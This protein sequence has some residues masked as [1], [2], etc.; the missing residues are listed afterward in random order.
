VPRDDQPGPRRD[1]VPFR[2]WPPVA[3]GIPLAGGIGLSLLVGEPIPWP[4]LRS[5][6]ALFLGAVFV[7]WNGWSILLFHRHATGLLPGQ[8][9]T[10]L[11]RSGPFAV[12][13]NPLYLGLIALYV[14][15]AV[16][17]PSTWAL[18]L[19]PLG[20]IVLLKGSVEPEESYLRQ[21]FG[22]AYEEY[23]RAVPRWF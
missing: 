19:L 4:D 12:S 13:R 22:L 6:V 11:L 17:V 10:A 21:K 16:A 1:A 3:L 20:F 8:P 14:A 5:G 18:L 9:T 2:V 23:C 15:I 7:G